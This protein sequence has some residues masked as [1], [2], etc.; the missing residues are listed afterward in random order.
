MNCEGVYQWRILTCAGEIR[1][2]LFE[3]KLLFEHFPGWKARNI[4]LPQ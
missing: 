1:H 3:G 4:S 2:D